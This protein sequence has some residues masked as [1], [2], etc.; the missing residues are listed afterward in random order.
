MVDLHTFPL[1]FRIRQKFN[2]TEVHDVASEV[3]AQLDRLSLADKIKANQ[4]VAITAGSRGIHKIDVILK[5]VVDYFKK[6]GAQPFIVPAMGSHGG[7]TVDG[8]LKILSSFGVTEAA[9][10]CPIKA[11]MDTIVV[12]ESTE[13][14][15]VHFDQMASQADHVFVCN[16]IKP[17]TDFNGQI[18]SGLM[19][20]LLIGLGKHHG[21][22]IYHRAIQDYSFDQ[23]LRSVAQEVI[24]RCNILAGLAIVEN[25]LDTTAKLEAVLPDQFEAREKELLQ[26]A[27]NSMARL[28]FDF[29]HVLLI[30]EIGKNISGTGMDTNVVGRKFDDHKATGAERPIIKRIIVRGL[31]PETDGNASG[32]GMSEFALSRAIQQM[33]VE[34][35]ATN[36]VTSNHVTAAMIPLHYAD[37]A[38]AMARALE[39]I[40]L[41]QPQDA[42][43]AWIRNT[44]QMETMEVS[45]AYWDEFQQ[46]TDL[47]ILCEPRPFT[48]D[49]QQ[50]LAQYVC[51]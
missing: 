21:A 18:Q 40:G 34:K 50:Y 42:K 26:L 35:T 24:Q 31:T 23:I 38:T 32:I 43:I 48:F 20:M 30:D 41:T 9:M 6:R 28:P 37:D 15:P 1:M 8:Q 49:A 44:L 51:E 39:T 7:G 27:T 47:E 17:H 25:S 13:G 22:R 29:A 14:I 16:R 4:T 45:Q 12:C 3:T 46:R 33:D 19:K 11:S 5:A 2:V 10:G 36:C